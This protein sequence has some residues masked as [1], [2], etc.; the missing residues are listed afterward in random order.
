MLLLM[1]W[2]RRGEEDD[3]ECGRE[4]IPTIVLWT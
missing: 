1:R 4:M 2:L 3:E